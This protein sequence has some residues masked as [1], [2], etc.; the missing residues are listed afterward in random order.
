MRLTARQL[1]RA[2]L[3]R[4]VLLEREPLD[5]VEAVHRAVALQAQEPAS[6]YLALWNRVARFNPADLDRAFSVHAVVKATLMRV[7]LHAVDGADYP[8]FH[9]AMQPTLRAAR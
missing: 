8:A 7:T 9:E 4:Q 3:A 2:T 5:I 1:N 6:P